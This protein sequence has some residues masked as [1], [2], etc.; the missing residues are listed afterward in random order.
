MCVLTCVCARVHVS[1][2]SVCMTN[3]TLCCTRKFCWCWSRP[4]IYSLGSAVDDDCFP[5]WHPTEFFSGTSGVCWTICQN[6]DYTSLPV[7]F[8]LTLTSSSTIYSSPCDFF[9][10]IFLMWTH[11]KG[12]LSYWTEHFLQAYKALLVPG[13]G[14]TTRSVGGDGGYGV[15]S[16]DVA[17]I[18]PV[19]WDFLCLQTMRNV[20]MFGKTN[21]W[22]E[23][24]FSMDRAWFF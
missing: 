19:H 17:Q 24:D 5:L 12:L 9:C 2:L 8:V 21:I 22:W 23:E 6:Y 15:K 16:S 3:E 4:L 10:F 7:L 1:F 20:V 13:Y 18:A 11:W 14:G